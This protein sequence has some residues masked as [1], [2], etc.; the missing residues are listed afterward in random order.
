MPRRPSPHCRQG[1]TSNSEKPLASTVVAARRIAAEAR[2]RGLTLVCAPCVM[3]F[4]QVRYAQALLC[5]GVIGEVYSARGQGHGGVPPWSGYTS[6]P[7]PFFAAGGGPALDMG[8]YPLH[9]LTGLLGPVRR[10]SAMTSRAQSSFTVADGPLQG[11]TVPIEVDDN[12]HMLLD[13]GNRRLASLEASNCIQG[14]RAPQLELMGLE[15]TIAVDV[16]DVAAPVEILR[17]GKGWEQVAVPHARAAGPD[18]LLG[19]EHLVEC[20]EMGAEPI[21]SAEHAV[22]VV[23][24][25]E[26]A[27]QSARDGHVY[28][29]ES[30]L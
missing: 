7:G 19:I 26:K 14:T 22:H 13:L 16:L 18:H 10:V 27:A 12:W 11:I 6:D 23:E 28:T 1:N 8:V 2:E 20:V 4:P 30:S 17:P 5:D 3:L 25:V 21:L 15:G 24:I 29:V 9:A